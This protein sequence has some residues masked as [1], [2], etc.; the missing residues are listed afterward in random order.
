[1]NPPSIDDYAAIGNGRCVGLISRAGSLD[2]LCWP[3]F[4]GPSL[5]GSLLDQ[6]SGGRWS[7]APAGS[8]DVDREYIG[9]TNVLRTRFSRAS[10]VLTLVDLM[11]VGDEAEKGLFPEHEVPVSERASTTEVR[12]GCGSPSG[13]RSDRR[14]DRPV[15]HVLG[16]RARRIAAA[17]RADT[18]RDRADPRV[19]DP[20]GARAEV[21]RA[22]P[23]PSGAQCARPQ[24]PRLL[25]IWLRRRGVHDFASGEDRR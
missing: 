25:A 6:K 15:A 18:H 10:G 4:D 22:S 16:E 11:P 24:V 8:Y 14:V 21:R 1:M 9:E 23:A 20:V 2:W 5:F 17:R 7:V 19:V 12:W 13:R 3:R